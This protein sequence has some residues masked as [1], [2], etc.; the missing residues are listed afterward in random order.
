MKTLIYQYVNPYFKNSDLSQQSIRKYCEL[1]GADYKLYTGDI[2]LA[3]YSPGALWGIFYP[4]LFDLE[5]ITQYDK[6]CYVDADILAVK[7][8]DNI[9]DVS[10]LISGC[11]NYASM[12]RNIETDYH[13]TYLHFDTSHFSK[14][15][16]GIFK[17]LS[18]IAGY[19]SRGIN[20]GVVLFSKPIFILLSE[21]LK[22]NQQR[23][24]NIDPIL[25]WELGRYDQ[26][27]L[28]IFIASTHSA[29]MTNMND[30]FNW[31]LNRVEYKD[32]WSATFIHYILPRNKRYLVEDF[33]DE[34]IL[35]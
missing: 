8:R 21:W 29:Y 17:R 10:G 15:N 31:R 26:T 11:H 7:N 30:K 27:I 25:W 1:V 34:R 28:N 23:M 14:E 3:G 16:Q 5:H 18:D 32:R 24:L 20:T 33:D 12:S 13:D 19:N 4:F 22:H 6:I 9:F 2:V 35:K